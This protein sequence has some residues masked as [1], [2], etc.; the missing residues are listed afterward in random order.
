MLEPRMS[1]LSVPVAAVGSAGVDEIEVHAVSPP[2]GRAAL[3][4]SVV[5]TSK[6]FGGSQVSLACQTSTE[7]PRARR[8]CRPTARRASP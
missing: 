1:T 7:K 5:T 3:T 6:A 2:P 8:P 4:R